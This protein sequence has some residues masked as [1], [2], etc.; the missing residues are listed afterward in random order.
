M[1]KKIISILLGVLL[2]GTMALAGCSTADEPD[3]G[4]KDAAEAGKDEAAPTD[5]PAEDTGSSER[6]K[7]TY[8]IWGTADEGT[9]V[10]AVADQFNSSQDKIEVEVMAIPWENYTTRLNT[11]AAANQLPDTGMLNENMVIPYSS[12]DM[13]LDSGSMYE[14]ASQPIDTV[15]FQYEG[16]TVAYSSANEILIL[17]YNKDMFDAAGVAYPP[18][19]VAH[20]W[21]WEEFVDAAKKLTL[22]S[23]GKHPGEDGF[24]S[25]SITQYGCMVENL[26]WQLEVWALSNGGGFYNSDGSEVTIDKPE[27]IE[28]IQ[29]IAD[30]YLVDHVAPLSTGLTDDGVPRSIITGT[31]AMTTNGTWNVGTSLGTARNEGLNY[32]VAVLPYMKDKVTINTGGVNAVFSQTEHPKEAMEWIKWYSGI[33]HN[34]DNLIATGIWMPIF[35]EYYTDETYTH[36]WVDNPN[37]PDYDQY[38][39]AVVDYAISDAAQKTAWYYTNNTVDFNTLLQSVLGDVWTGAK[40]A[41]DAITENIDALRAAHAGEDK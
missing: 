29:R 19:D 30:L 32:G 11:M 40:T 8:T 22:D 14:G 7:I 12:N 37:F 24:N 5:K 6:V 41:K 38:K 18:A 28:A 3:N 31:V 20:A 13:L 26:T 1:S 16:K 27:S 34:W 23:N 35:Q 10:Q 4:P 33:E 21:T 2:L 9:N 15:A 25:N 39:S 17:Y 36:K